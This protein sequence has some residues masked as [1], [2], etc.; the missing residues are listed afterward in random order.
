MMSSV[1]KTDDT[2]INI[3]YVKNMTAKSV[4]C[5]LLF[6]DNNE[7]VDFNNSVYI[8]LDVRNRELTP[9]YLSRGRYAVL[10]HDVEST[11]ILAPGYPVYI[12]SAESEMNQGLSLF[13]TH[14][15]SVFTCII[16]KDDEQV[17]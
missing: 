3:P 17:N 1:L 5:A 14:S 13:L 8:V 2:F 11:G 7:H 12:E 6:F 15:R 10:S 9:P 16:K 4:L